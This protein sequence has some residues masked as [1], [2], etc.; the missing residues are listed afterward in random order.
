MDR[1]DVVKQFAAEVDRAVPPAE[2]IYFVG[3]GEERTAWYLHHRLIQTRLLAD[4]SLDVQIGR[5][6]MDRSAY[7]LCRL[8]NE[9]D[10]AKSASVDAITRS[11]DYRGRGE[12]FEQRSLV[13]VTP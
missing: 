13:R 6:P 1:G 9:A 2:P 7:V 8:P 12:A 10:L 11:K 3:V 4:D 5:L